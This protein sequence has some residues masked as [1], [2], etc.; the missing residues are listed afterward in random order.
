M[1]CD[2]VVEMLIWL[3]FRKLVTN[4]FR[5]V[6]KYYT[7][8]AMLQPLMICNVLQKVT[9]NVFSFE[10]LVVEDHVKP[11]EIWIKWPLQRFKNCSW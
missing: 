9:S 10:V 11:L 3:F 4:E 8:I 7:T 1:I 2:I 6:V 5:N